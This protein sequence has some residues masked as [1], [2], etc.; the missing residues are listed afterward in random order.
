M[1]IILDRIELADVGANPERLAAAIHSQVGNETGPVPVHDIARALD[2]VDIREEP[3]CNMEAA[4]LTDHER[5]Y[6]AILL[7]STSSPQRRRFSLGHELG[8]FVNE[9]HRT[10]SV[11][12]FQGARSDMVEARDINRH[13]RQEA[14]A[15][16]FSIELLTPRARL[17]PYLRG[18]VSLEHVDAMANDFDIS[19]QAAARRYVQ[20][21]DASL[22]V[23]F[24][25]HG[26]LRMIDRS[27]DGPRLAFWIGDAL[28]DMEPGRSGIRTVA[29]DGW[30]ASPLT[31]DVMIDVSQQADGWITVLI[32]AED[33]RGEQDN[34]AWASPRL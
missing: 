5:S 16:L 33:G 14:E 1:G 13:F 25:R 29:A 17:K 10:T 32:N 30:V 21:H 7:N 20:L 15:N 22:A 24:C 9:Y 18:E 12:G 2:I 27:P 6:G 19:R 11:T 34:G 28:P 4:L 31:D 26:R 8:H 23:L 3:L